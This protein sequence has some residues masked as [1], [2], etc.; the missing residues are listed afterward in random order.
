MLLNFEDGCLCIKKCCV[1]AYNVNGK[2]SA[3]LPGFILK[4]ES[5]TFLGISSKKLVN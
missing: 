4:S 3:S 1:S 5:A 2:F